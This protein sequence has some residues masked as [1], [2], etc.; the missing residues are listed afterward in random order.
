[1]AIV[2]IAQAGSLG[3][4]GVDIGGSK[5]TANEDGEE[6]LQAGRAAARVCGGDVPRPR[7]GDRAC[8]RRSAS[9]TRAAAKA[10]MGARVEARA[11]RVVV[12]RE[13]MNEGRHGLGQGWGGGGVGGSGDSNGAGG[14]C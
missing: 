6:K 13:L 3:M 9:T 11:N 5:Q 14:G 4:A 8:G 1:M 2:N 10:K 7:C 12:V